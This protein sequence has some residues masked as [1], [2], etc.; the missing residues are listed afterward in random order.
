MNVDE[1]Y[2]ALAARITVAVVKHETNDWPTS[3]DGLR[4]LVRRVVADSKDSDL[5]L[6]EKAS[7][8]KRLI[9]HI[10]D[11]EHIADV[12]KRGQL[13]RGT[14]AAFGDPQEPGS[15]RARSE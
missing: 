13:Q 10:A 11:L 4:D 9:S 3:F 5:S 15:F 8:I 12:R 6:I 7:L 14:S 2:S 1:L